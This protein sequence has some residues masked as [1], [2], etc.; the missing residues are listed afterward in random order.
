PSSRNN[1]A[2]TPERPG[3]R[4]SIV[5]EGTIRCNVFRNNFF[6]NALR[7][8]LIPKLILEKNN[9]QVPLYVNASQVSLKL[10]SVF[11]YPS[12]L[13]VNTAFGPHSV[14]PFVI[15]VK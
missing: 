14:S 4:S 10:K 3:F 2:L 12:R 8:S 6:E 5:R 9:F 15:R 7:Y 11:P 13:K 1:K